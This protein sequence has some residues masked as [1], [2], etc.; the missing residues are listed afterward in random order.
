MRG[1]LSSEKE[2]S[3]DELLEE[4]WRQRVAMR[5]RRKETKENI[6]RESESDKYTNVAFSSVT[7]APFQDD[8][9]ESWTNSPA[10]DCPED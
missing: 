6:R 10:R 7:S 3:R 8:A 4:R 2:A 9:R 1:W 5:E